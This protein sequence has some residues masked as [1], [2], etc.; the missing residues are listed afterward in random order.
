MLIKVLI[1]RK[2]HVRNLVRSRYTELW[3]KWKQ[4]NP[5][6]R[7]YNR[8]KL[9]ANIKNVLSVNGKAFNENVFKNATIN[10]WSGRKV[11]YYAHWYFLVRF[12]WGCLEMMA[13]QL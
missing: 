4:A 11:L 7:G 12:Q 9:N 2:S 10:R 5:Q 6:N 8:T 13:M 3:K 1:P